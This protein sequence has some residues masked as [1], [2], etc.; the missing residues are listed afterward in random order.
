MHLLQWMH[1]DVVE[2]PACMR[3]GRSGS[4]SRARAMATKAN[5]SAS[6]I[7]IV[8]SSVMPPSRISGR[9]QR[10]LELAG[11][12]E[13]ERLLVGVGT[14]EAVADEAEAEP[15]RCGQRGAE[16]LQRRVAAEEVHRVGQRAAPGELQR[17]ER[18]VGL[19]EPGD[20]DALVEPQA[21]VDAVGHV[22]LGRHRHVRAGGVA[23]RAQDGA[24]E[25]GAVLHRA[26][27]LVVAAVE[28]G[29]QE[30]AQ[31]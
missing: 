20:L 27:E 28:L 1:S 7:S 22:E 21:A 31:R 14:Q 8:A 11:V 29:A 17:I 4:R 23:H 2:V 16:L 5:P 26:A 13:E 30:G 10:A 6:A 12:G 25:A 19:E 24:G 3:L 18:A 15:H 9:G